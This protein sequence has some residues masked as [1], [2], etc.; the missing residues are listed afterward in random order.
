MLRHLVVDTPDRV[1]LSVKRRTGETDAGPDAGTEDAFLLRVRARDERFKPIEDA[2]ASI[3]VTEPG[4]ETVELRAR[5]V[6]GEP[7]VLEVPYV[8]RRSGGYRVRAE[9]ADGSGEPAGSAEAGFTV[10][11]D[12]A[13]FGSL[14][15]NRALLGA[16]AERT[17]GRVLEPAE[18]AEFAG[19]L[20]ER[21]APITE[22]W[23]R[24]LWHTP[25]L[26]LLALG[27]FVAEWILR[28]RRGL[29]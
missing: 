18:L 19:M 23:I 29:P 28:R 26:F 9:V 5:R 16:I 6:S 12:A 1:E 8:P 2:S 15:P 17:G 22:P 10:D 13:E 24:P 14:K 3:E 20:P 25:A 21:E 4:G 11:F 7:G 27:C